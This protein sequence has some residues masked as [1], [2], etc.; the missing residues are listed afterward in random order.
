MKEVQPDWVFMDDEAFGSGWET[1]SI[2][3]ALSANAQARAMPREKPLDLAWRMAGEMMQSWTACLPK[4]SP[5]TTPAW[6][7]SAFPDQVFASA[8]IV[9]QPS[10]YGAVHYLDTFPAEVRGSKLQ[11]GKMANGK[12]HHLLPWLTAC[13]YGQ[14][15]AVL[16]LESALHSFGGGATG[17]SYFGVFPAGCFDD[18]AKMLALSTATALATLFED[19]FMDGKPIIPKDFTA[20][21]GSLRAWSGMRL[22]DSYWVV[23]TPGLPTHTLPSDIAVS[24]KVAQ[25]DSVLT[26][27]TS[28]DLTTGETHAV[29]QT[30]KGIT[31]SDLKL[32]RTTVLHIA[33]GAASK[34]TKLPADVWLPQPGY[35]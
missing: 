13:T 27:W 9:A 24:L 29:L 8:G 12:P 11:Q 5:H 34:C 31:I 10:M 19:H 7:N 20:T 23:L 33:S 14:M 3:A 6:Y 15:S 26:S 22:A 35:N 4:V 17:F 18:P 32:T 28:C 25:P 2:D 16:A 1:W 30:A 21:V